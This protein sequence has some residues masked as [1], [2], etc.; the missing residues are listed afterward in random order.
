MNHLIFKIRTYWS[1]KYSSSL[2]IFDL[3]LLLLNSIIMDQK[4]VLSFRQ[5]ALKDTPLI[6]VGRSREE[7]AQFWISVEIMMDF[8]NF[9]C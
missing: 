4:I 1:E 8:R 7:H 9:F 2:I 5:F 3:S 6:T